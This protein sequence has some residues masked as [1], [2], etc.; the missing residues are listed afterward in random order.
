MPRKPKFGKMEAHRT[1]NQWTYI[2]VKWSKV[3]V[4][5]PAYFWDRKCVIS[6][7]REGLRTSNLVYRRSTK[8]R[9]SA[10]RR[11]RQGQ[12]S[13]VKVTRPTNGDTESVSYLLNEKAYQL[14]TW[15]TVEAWRAATQAVPWPPKSRVMVTRLRGPSNRC[16]PIRRELN[17]PETAK[18]VAWLRM[19]RAIMHTSFKVKKSKVKVT[20]PII[21]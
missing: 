6:S 20:R 16:W 15:Y 17:V 19:P 2:E 8:T 5:R 21:A 9:I 4:T 3:K 1:S 12:M 11:D 10:K 18:L 13:R 7:E 14:E